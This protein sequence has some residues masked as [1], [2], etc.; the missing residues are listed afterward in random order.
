MAEGLGERTRWD[1]LRLVQIDSEPNAAE[2][3]GQSGE[4]AADGRGGTCAEAVVEEEGADINASR[5]Q[6]LRGGAGLSNGWV[7][8]QSEEDRTE[9]VSLLD[10]PSA[11]NGLQSN[12]A[13]TSEQGALVAVTAV[14]PRREGREMDTN[15]PQDSCSMNCVEGIGHINRDSNLV[16]VGAVTRKPLPSNMNDSL[17]PIR[18]L[19]PELQRRSH[20]PA[21]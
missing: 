19:D 6:D 10:T 14:D 11:V 18:S 16:R 4:E 15:G 3:L 8:S 12:V 21:R 20:G 1:D 7:N 17:T 13:R 9:G 5:M 2:A